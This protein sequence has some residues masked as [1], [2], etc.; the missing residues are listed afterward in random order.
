MRL[1]DVVSSRID[2]DR[3]NRLN[4]NISKLHDDR[5]TWYVLLIGEVDVDVVSSYYSNFYSKTVERSKTG[6]V[7]S[8][9]VDIYFI[10]TQTKHG[11]ADQAA[12]VHIKRDRSS[13]S[14]R[15]SMTSADQADHAG[16]NQIKP[17]K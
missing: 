17:I 8:R 1:N 15:S 16:E 14:C 10:G 2:F 6:W 7:R 13:R 9:Y 5:H 3:V 11:Y 4:I 12:Q